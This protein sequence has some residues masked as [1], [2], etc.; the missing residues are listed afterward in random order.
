MYVGSTIPLHASSYRT[1]NLSESFNSNLMEKVQ[2]IPWCQNKFPNQ[3]GSITLVSHCC[4][5]GKSQLYVEKSFAGF[6]S[7]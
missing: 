4:K 7:I 2:M 6:N 3:E 5:S 1:M